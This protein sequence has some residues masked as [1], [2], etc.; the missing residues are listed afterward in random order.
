MRSRSF[1]YVFS[2]EKYD[3]QSI[4]TITGAISKVIKGWQKQ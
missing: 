1:H 2:H 3:Q 4:T